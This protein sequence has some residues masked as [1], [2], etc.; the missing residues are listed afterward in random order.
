MTSNSNIK[1]TFENLNNYFKDKG[2]ANKILVLD[3]SHFTKVEES[4]CNIK[5]H[6]FGFE[7]PVLS[8]KEAFEKAA[9]VSTWKKFEEPI[10]RSIH[11]FDSHSWKYDNEVNDSMYSQE[12]EY[13]SKA[14][15]ENNFKPQDITSTLVNGPGNTILFLAKSVNN[16]EAQ[17]II[18]ATLKNQVD[19]PVG[20]E[21]FNYRT[22]EKKNLPEETRDFLEKCFE[23]LGEL[24]MDEMAHSLYE[25][26]QNTEFEKH[27]IEVREKER[28][29][30]FRKLFHSQKQHLAL[31][32]YLA[33]EIGAK[34]N[35][36]VAEVIEYT[37][38]SLSEFLDINKYISDSSFT[39]IKTDLLSDLKRLVHV[40]NIITSDKKIL[41]EGIR[42]REFQYDNIVDASVSGNL[43]CGNYKEVSI[44]PIILPVGI[45]KLIFKE[46]IVN[47]IQHSKWDEPQVEINVVEKVDE[48][49]FVFSNK[50]TQEMVDKL[51]ESVGNNNHGR[52][53][54]ESLSRKIGWSVSYS[55][56]KDELK[57]RCTVYIKK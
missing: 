11:N 25:S 21:S 10:V 42:L 4:F 48:I 36:E 45:P 14:P 19:L 57:V 39:A 32:S 5:I 55:G 29:L 38:K 9:K 12:P 41:E 46:I 18:Y 7:N 28:D 3:F 50:V 15:A 40:F 6:L 35:K 53:L 22:D 31:L 8:Y 33:K 44:A 54:I 34:E 37:Q 2:I 13:F 56:L 16:D 24:L 20:M 1:E 43:F 27:E 52:D 30:I 47:A 17:S 23:S 51:K 26:W 49:C